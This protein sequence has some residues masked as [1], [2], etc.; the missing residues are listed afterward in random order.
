M[1]SVFEF[2]LGMIPSV[3][4]WNRRYRHTYMF[5][6]NPRGEEKLVYCE[7]SDENSKG[8]YIYFQGRDG[9]S[10]R[11]AQESEHSI[12]VRFPESGW[13]NS[14]SQGIPLFWS[15]QPARQWH[16]G[17]CNKNST[18]STV[19]SVM[20]M[21]GQHAEISWDNVQDALKE[22]TLSLTEALKRVE[23]NWM[24][25]ALNR[26]LVLL[27]GNSKE[28]YLLH[29]YGL[30]GKVTKDTIEVDDLSVQDVL[31]F[32]KETNELGVFNVTNIR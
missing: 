27:R 29:G 1:K 20:I 32:L 24:G 2:D 18:I 7:G 16:R 14:A 10:F 19:E 30:I 5:L 6:V 28:H 21:Y 23:K 25:V 3:E 31:D 26:Q 12:K 4:E 17:I 9:E 13:F 15:R 8:I 11:I 22:E